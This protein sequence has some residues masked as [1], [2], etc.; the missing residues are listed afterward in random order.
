M[1]GTTQT[2]VFAAVA[3]SM[4]LAACSPT[5]QPDAAHSGLITENEALTISRKAALDAGHDL[6][7]YHLDT[8]GDRTGGDDKEWL[9]VYLCKPVPPPPGCS[10]MVVVDRRSGASRIVQG[11]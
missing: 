10:F 3:L 9:F 8:S 2:K 1:S 11:M 4:L 6:E 5:A 7:R